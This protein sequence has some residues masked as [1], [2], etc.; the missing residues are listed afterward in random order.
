MCSSD[1][2]LPDGMSELV[3]VNPDGQRDTM[4]LGVTCVTPKEVFNT[5]Y[6]DEADEFCLDLDELLGA[7]VSA[8][9]VCDGTEAAELDLIDGEF[10]L[11]CLGVEPGDDQA[12]LVV[13]DEYGICDTTYLYVEVRNY[14]NI[15]LPDTLRTL[16]VTAVDLA[17]GANDTLFGELLDVFITEEPRFGMAT[18]N[19]DGTITYLP[20]PGYCDDAVADQFAYEICT[21]YDCAEGMVYVITECE[22]LFVH[23]GF[24]PN[25]DGVND[26]WRIAGLERFPDH[27]L[28]VFNRWG[29]EVLDTRRYAGDWDGT[30]NGQDLPDGTYF[31]VLDLGDGELRSGYVQIER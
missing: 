22:D 17:P 26:T 3:L 21:Q 5:I 11:S 8:V 25:N 30:W 19:E 6:V 9:N 12:C 23:T 24:S 2:H 20:N 29:T 16:P 10:C 4:M 28:R 18:V 27:S 14:V 1:L 7:P 13:C 31:Y 15:A